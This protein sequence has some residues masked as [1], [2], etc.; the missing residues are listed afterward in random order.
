MCD[1]NECLLDANQS[2]ESIGT[3][4]L[5]DRNRHLPPL[6][7]SGAS[8]KVCDWNG[9]FPLKISPWGGSQKALPWNGALYLEWHLPPL[10]ITLG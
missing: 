7:D 9:T 4:F 2:I 8:P 10:S 3:N 1:T 6:F 5:V